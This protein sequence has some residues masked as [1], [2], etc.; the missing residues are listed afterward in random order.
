MV[1][2]DL[3]V[4]SQPDTF[5]LVGK[6]KSHRAD[7]EQF[8]DLIRHTHFEDRPVGEDQHIRLRCRKPVVE[9]HGCLSVAI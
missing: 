7:S 9:R 1:A 8:G 4:L 6:L 5:A 2:H 3:I